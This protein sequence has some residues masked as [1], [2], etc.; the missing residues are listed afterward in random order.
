MAKAAEI[1]ISGMP[2]ERVVAGFMSSRSPHLPDPE[3]T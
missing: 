2:G 1:G 3:D